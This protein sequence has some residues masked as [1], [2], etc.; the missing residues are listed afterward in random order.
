MK[1]IVTFLR[2]ISRN[3]PQNKWFTALNGIGLSLGLALGML[4]MFY[5]KYELSFDRNYALSGNIFRVTGYGIIGD[6]TLNTA[7]TPVPLIKS[8]TKFYPNVIKSTQLTVGANKLVRYGEKSFAEHRFIYADTSFFSVFDIPL[9]SG[10]AATALKEPLSIVITQP[11]AKRYFGFENPMGKVMELDNGLKLMVT[12][13]CEEPESNSHLKF[14]MVASFEAINQ[15]YLMQADSSHLEKWKNNWLHFNAFNYVVVGDD[16]DP[17][18]LSRLISD[19]AAPQMWEQLRSTLPEGDQSYQNTSFSFALQDIRDIHLKSKLDNELSPNSDILHVK[20]ALALMVLILLITVINF[21]N[22]TTSHVQRRM[23]EVQVRVLNGA[24]KIR[25]F[26]QFLLESFA[27]TMVAFFVALVVVELLF[28]FFNSYLNLGIHLSQVRQWSDLLMALAIAILVGLIT[29]LVPAMFYSG[30]HSN[31]EQNIKGK[32]G[33]YWRAVLVGVQVAGS[34]AMVILSIGIWWQLGAIKKVNLGYNPQ[35]LLVIERAYALGDSLSDFKD[36]L[37]KFGEIESITTTSHIPGDQFSV[38][39]FKKADSLSEQILLWNV[40]FVDADFAST[41]QIPLR[42]GSFFALGDTSYMAV[43]HA[44]INEMKLDD[45]RETGYKT[46]G[47][48]AFPFKVSGVLNNFYFN[49]LKSGIGPTVFLPQ[50]KHIRYMVI[51]YK[52]G[53]KQQATALAQSVWSHMTKN[54][55]F[56]SYLLTDRIGKFYNQ[57]K[58][59][60]RLTLILAVFSM[61]M[62]AL[63]VIG[64]TVFNTC[65]SGKEIAIRRQQG[66]SGFQLITWGLMKLSVFV[67]VGVALALPSAWSLLQVWLSPFFFKNELMAMHYIAIAFVVAL[68]TIWLMYIN[69]KKSLT[70]LIRQQ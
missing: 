43:N 11:A 50:Q 58:K 36:K 66:A 39:A 5:A 57:D 47:N 14:D 8:L 24:S 44:L 34:I 41:F 48:E 37:L 33:F 15:L 35:N 52:D 55:P 70:E 61:F 9:L 32:G 38:L 68:V 12:G 29:G 4:V 1:P 18:Q 28:P 53:K 63:S 21:V 67:F 26:R 69:L 7:T 51:R 60:G 22:L 31:H 62:C 56:D 17:T 64:L 40:A 16:V 20:I 10:D 13:V 25:L 59:L 30:M 3:L 42:S 6:D 54:E 2:F 27:N 49:D 65:L 23:R 46:L 45:F 19:D